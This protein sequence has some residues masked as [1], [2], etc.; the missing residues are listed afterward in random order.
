MAIFWPGA[1]STSCYN[2]RRCRD[3]LE[4]ST[5]LVVLHDA[6]TSHWLKFCDPHEMLV[7]THIDD[8][9]PRLRTVEALTNDTGWWA[10][11][12]IS[13]EAAPA[14][15]SALQTRPPSSFPLLWFGLYDEPAPIELPTRRD[16]KAYVLGDWAPSVSRTAYDEAISRIKAHIARGDTYQ[17]NYS[18]RLRAPFSGDT[19][20]FFLDLARAQQADYVAYVK[21]GEAAICSASP[22]V[23]FRLNGRHIVSRPMKGTAARGRTLA[24]DEAQARWLRHS[25]K[26]R[27]ENVMIVDM[28][29]NDIGRVAEIGSV[30]VPSLFNVERYPTV[31]QMTSTVTAKTDAT[32]TEILTALFPCAS[33]TGA[34]KPCTMHIIADLETTPRC[35]YTGCIGY[36]APNRRAQF[37]V[38][39]R[40]VLVDEAAG[41]AEYG[42]GGGI[43]WDSESGSE[44]AECQVKAQ[45]LTERRP[46]FSLLETM[47][48]TPED[49]YFLLD[50]HLRRLQGSATYFGFP[51]E[52]AQVEEQLS[53]LAASLPDEPHKA[54]LLVA[55]DGVGG[56]P[57]VTIEAA[58]LHL[59]QPARRWKI[60]LA[61]APVDSA[62]RFLYHK[63]THRAVYAD[64][65][66]A[67]PDCDDVLL[68]NERG[69]IT[70][71]TIANVVVELDGELVTP[72]VDCGLLAGTFRAWLLDQRQIRE[73]TITIEDL[74]ESDEI[75][76]INSVRKW[77][78]AKLL[79]SDL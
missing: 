23:F 15:D 56:T 55:R 3:L 57:P 18:F 66:D 54:R 19:W 32:L 21:A 10:A 14:F 25:E 65:H 71:T 73:Q 2:R 29:R 43:V 6:A 44:Y 42:V 27:A 62:N 46:E 41:Q 48:W 50:Y 75:Y 35:T 52:I 17:V 30:R 7:A 59:D 16:A 63:T 47:L 36:I 79:E 34:P 69:E 38:A 31:W 78:K 70:E 13:Y 37:N 20:A 22:E 64:A 39:I 76:L 74:K 60:R 77:R 61:P 4:E 5:N 24:E 12:F 51:V 40:T 8:V 45:V 53:A 67:C 11:G 1:R 49:G 28:I 9:V 72:P 26:N 68:W 58:P 33:I